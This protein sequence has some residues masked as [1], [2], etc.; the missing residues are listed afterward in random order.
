MLKIIQDKS[1]VQAGKRASGAALRSLS[2]SSAGETVGVFEEGELSAIESFG[3]GEAVGVLSETTTELEGESV[4]MAGEGESEGWLI[5][6]T[7]Q[8]I[9]SVLVEPSAACLPSSF[10][11]GRCPRR[12][13]VQ[14]LERCACSP[15]DLC[16]FVHTR[17]DY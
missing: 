12:W 8:L 1:R 11:F 13:T 10:I 5:L 9:I 6:S 14:P 4:E 16:H 7:H 2:S 17:R 3:V 15:I